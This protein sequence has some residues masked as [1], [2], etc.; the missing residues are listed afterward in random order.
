MKIKTKIWLS[1]IMMVLIPIAAALSLGYFGWVNLDSK[2][3]YSLEKMFE[4]ENAV[5]SAQSMIYS[6]QEELWDTNWQELEEEEVGHQD[7]E[8]ESNIKWSELGGNKNELTETKQMHNLGIEMEQMGYHF[9]VFMDGDCQYSNLTE[10]DSVILQQVAGE[11]I[12]HTRSL[13]IGEGDYSVIKNTFEED[14]TICVMI[15]VSNGGSGKT[16]NGISQLKQYISY[17]ICIFFVSIVFIIFLT[18]L[19]LSGFITK[20]I[21]PPLQK[22]RDGTK[23]IR[24]GDLDT[25]I[26]YQREDEI[27]DVCKDFE[28][29]RGYL[30]ESA[31][32]RIAYESYRRELISGISHDL[33]TPLTSIKGYLEGLTMGI[34]KDIAMQERYYNAMKTRTNDLENLVDSLSIY[35]KLEDHSKKSLSQEIDFK[36]F[37]KKY[38]EER[39]I[40][41]EKEKIQVKLI[42]QDMAYKIIADSEEMV[43]VFDNL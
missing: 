38:L 22:L 2:Y 15:A 1:N 40:E 12:T 7:E 19:I 24:E 5:V 21:L 10:E 6:Y 41:Q 42:S 26:N 39:K 37:L 20:S 27:G 23:R 11:A 31:L 35:N 33:R 9:S 17:F 30:K 14:G 18:N 3:I 34:A 29:M 32:E 28:E 16:A 36:E 4:D 25:K 13:V 8:D 43:R